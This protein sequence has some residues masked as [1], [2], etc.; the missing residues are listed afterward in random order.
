MLSPPF[1]GQHLP[2][3]V[4]RCVAKQKYGRVRDVAQ[5]P[6]APERVP[7]PS[8][9]LGLVGQPGCTLGVSDWAG[10]D[11]VGA[12]ATRAFLDCEDRRE[13]IYTR[14]RG[15]HVN[16]VRRRWGRGSEQRGWCHKG[17]WAPLWCSIALT[18]MYAPC[19]A[20]IWGNVAFTVLKVPICDAGQGRPF[21]RTSNDARYR[22]PGPF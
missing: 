22:F 11:D 9:L 19:D 2:R 20:R 10:R 16:L 15:R 5:V 8:G 4:R 13:G 17:K 12:H 7:V 3:N 1:D 18:W 14:F 21:I 6:D